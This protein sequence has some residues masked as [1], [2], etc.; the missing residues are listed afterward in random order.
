MPLPNGLQGFFLVK[1]VALFG[2]G[3][4]GAAQ[5]FQGIIPALAVEEEEEEEE[6]EEKLNVDDIPVFTY[7]NASGNQGTWFYNANLFLNP[8]ADGPWPLT[9]QY[10]PP[11]GGTCNQ[12]Y[13]RGGMISTTISQDGWFVNST[14][15]GTVLPVSCPFRQQDIPTWYS[16]AAC[17]GASYAFPDNLYPQY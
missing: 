7:V 4:W 11:G 3:S 16:S 14:N 9:V 13:S 15:I 10:I 2:G 5:W 17:A 12:P 1:G 6:T 8:N